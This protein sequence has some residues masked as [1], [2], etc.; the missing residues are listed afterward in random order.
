ML[1]VIQHIRAFVDRS[2]P[3]GALPYGIE[4]I[5]RAIIE[6]TNVDRIE[7]VGFRDSENPM[8]G[9]FRRYEREDGVYSG[10]KTT[11]EVR[12]E[13]SL[14]FCWSR[15]VICKELCHSLETDPKVRVRD[16]AEVEKLL[17]ALRLNGGAAIPY[18]PF[19]SEK[20]AEFTALELLCPV[21]DR[22]KA[23]KARAAGGISDM[24][25]ATEFRV[26]VRFVPA[27]FNPTYIELI[28][29]LFKSV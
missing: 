22:Q 2:H 16:F 12:H 23:S 15:F 6:I 18:P 21:R 8:K 19:I 26:P 1:Q 28:H 17:N 9:Q 13:L 29:Q 3:Q 27:L 11:V 7:L 24:Q 5:R 4:P 10:T 14:N 20:M 25:I